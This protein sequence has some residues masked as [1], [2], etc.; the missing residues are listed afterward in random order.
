MTQ[1]SNLDL[2]D[3]SLYLNLD[4]ARQWDPACP[5]LL[6][7]GALTASPIMAAS[8]GV[9]IPFL[10]FAMAQFVFLY[11]M[12]CENGRHDPGTTG[13]STEGA[14]E[15]SVFKRIASARAGSGHHS[16]RHTSSSKSA[17]P[18][19]IRTASRQAMEAA[20]AQEIGSSRFAFLPGY[21]HTASR[22]SSMDAALAVAQ[23][24]GGYY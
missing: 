16:H 1:F 21:V 20:S 10:L 2:L 6:P 18:G 14:E 22:Q 24:N 8:M 3:E 19:H 12:W 13:E 15:S 5:V 11:R 23:G 17:I 4:S 9:L 7:L